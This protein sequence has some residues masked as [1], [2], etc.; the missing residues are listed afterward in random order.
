MQR[1]SLGRLRQQA[2]NR[3]QPSVSVRRLEITLQVHGQE[4]GPGVVQLGP[5]RLEI[6]ACRVHHGLLYIVTDERAGTAE[7]AVDD[8]SREWG[9]TLPG[10][11][12]LLLGAAQGDDV[13]LH[14]AV[15]ARERDEAP[16][17]ELPRARTIA[18]VLDEQPAKVAPSVA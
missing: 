6:P 2:R 14:R 15:V 7:I 5:T 17:T 1:S 18:E 10:R 8:A 3:I 9:G 4:L 16:V 12:V 11:E 13:H